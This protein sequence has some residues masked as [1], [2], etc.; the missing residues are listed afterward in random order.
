[1][2]KGEK[3]PAPASGATAETLPTCGLYQL[4]RAA[5]VQLHAAHQT[6]GARVAAEAD[7]ELLDEAVGAPLLTMEHAR[8]CE[9]ARATGFV[10][11]TSRG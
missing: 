9:V 10:M 4:L 3:A 2:R 6:I 7:S 11:I 8:W 1:M 5:G